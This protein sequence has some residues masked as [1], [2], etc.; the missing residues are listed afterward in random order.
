MKFLYILRNFFSSSVTGLALGP[1][2]R[3]KILKGGI[4]GGKKVKETEKGKKGGK[5]KK[6]V[7]ICKGQQPYRWN[8]E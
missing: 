5:G 2:G 6:R 1:L 7:G 8:H 4:S 3:N